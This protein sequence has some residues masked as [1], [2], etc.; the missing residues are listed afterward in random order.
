MTHTFYTGPC[1][2]RQMA[3]KFREAGFLVAFFEPSSP[4]GQASARGPH[5]NNGEGTEKVYV[6]SSLACH[7][8][9]E[10]LRQKHGTSFGLR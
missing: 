2:V 3:A 1:I 8:I 4:C 7:E 6:Q 5:G 10:A 9:L